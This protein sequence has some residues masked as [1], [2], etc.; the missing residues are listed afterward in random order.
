GGQDRRLP[1]ES[2]TGPNCAMRWDTPP[3]R[4]RQGARPPRTATR[5]LARGITLLPRGHLGGGWAPATLWDAGLSMTTPSR[6]TATARGFLSLTVVR[7]PRSVTVSPVNRGNFT[8]RAPPHPWRGRR[9]RGRLG[10]R[11]WRR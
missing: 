3:A 2:A 8:S 9:R 5:G 7:N 1:S 10:S 11:P 6:I 4:D